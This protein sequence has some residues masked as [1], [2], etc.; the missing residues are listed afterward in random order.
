MSSKSA[1]WVKAV[2]GAVGA[3]AAPALATD[4]V[5]VPDTISRGQA[6]HVASV[7]TGT[8]S[9][10]VYGYSAKV[11]AWFACQNATQNLAGNQSTGM[12]YLSDFDRIYV[13]VNTISV[14]PI[15]VWVGFGGH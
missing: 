12:E 2:D 14:A 4:G 15:T 7:K 10:T 3:T 11:S 6:I 1:G 8:A 13:R 9:L 5:A